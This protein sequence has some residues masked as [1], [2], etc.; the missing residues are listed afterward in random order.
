MSPVAAFGMNFLA[1]VLVLLLI[2]V[3]VLVACFVGV[4]WRKSKNSKAA[5]IS[6]DEESAASAEA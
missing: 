5:T 1:Y 2:V 4:K 3:L 6:S